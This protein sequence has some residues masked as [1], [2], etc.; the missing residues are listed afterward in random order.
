MHPNIHFPNTTKLNTVFSHQKTSFFDPDAYAELIA[1]SHFQQRILR[2]GPFTASL[3]RLVLKNARLDLGNYSQPGF[4]RGAI[5]T[6]WMN[7]GITRCIAAA[8]LINGFTV[9]RSDL[10]IYGEGTQLEYRSVP[11][12]PW[13]AL[14]V[15]REELQHRALTTRLR[16]LDICDI[17]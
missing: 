10:Q 11:N 17:D 8:P 16:E 6:S 4:G 14:Q 1:D 2:G 5:L 12:A 13:Y 15:R 9:Q 3:D 7:I